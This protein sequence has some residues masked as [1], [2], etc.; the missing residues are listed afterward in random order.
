VPLREAGRQALELAL[1]G[2]D[3]TVVRIP[4]EV[5]LRASTPGTGS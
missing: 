4:A 3:D 2:A 5:V 1:S